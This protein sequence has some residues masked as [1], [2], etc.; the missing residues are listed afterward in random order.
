M[1][2]DHLMYITIYIAEEQYQMRITHQDTS[3]HFLQKKKKKKKDTSKHFSYDFFYHLR[4][5]T[6]FLE[7]MFLMKVIMILTGAEPEGGQ[8]G[9][10]PPLLIPKKSSYFSIKQTIPQYGI[11]K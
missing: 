10:L 5:N 4:K 2:C 1:N 9:H 11:N 8:G 6:K 7:E 3:K